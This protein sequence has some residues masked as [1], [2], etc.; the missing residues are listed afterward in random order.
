MLFSI[1]KASNLTTINKPASFNFNIPQTSTKTWED[2]MEWEDDV[3]DDVEEEVVEEAEVTLEE[4]ILILGKGE[5]E[6]VGEPPYFLRNEPVLL[7]IQFD[8]FA[9]SYE[10][11]FRATPCCSDWWQCTFSVLNADTPT[12][13]S[14]LF[15]SQGNYLVD[16]RDEFAKY[17]SIHSSCGLQSD[18]FCY[19]TT[20]EGHTP[21]ING[22]IEDVANIL[23]NQSNGYVLLD[24]LVSAE[25]KIIKWI[26]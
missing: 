22:N 8:G 20:H 25:A 12:W 5:A 14:I 9:D 26:F 19:V 3:E 21:D 17:A 2:D 13:G 10:A 16:G 18:T 7:T 11:V 15:C 6:G 24:E 1:D 23:T 4:G